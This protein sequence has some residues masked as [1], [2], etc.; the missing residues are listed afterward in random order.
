MAGTKDALILSGAHVFD[1]SQGTEYL[2]KLKTIPNNM[3]AKRVKCSSKSPSLLRCLSSALGSL[4]GIRTLSGR[5]CLAFRASGP[6]SGRSRPASP[7]VS[8]WSRKANRFSLAR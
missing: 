8:G 5:A 3:E 7:S 4:F 6:G 2:G 1:P